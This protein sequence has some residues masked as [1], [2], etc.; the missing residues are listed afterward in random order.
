M[1]T[2]VAKKELFSESDVDAIYG[3]YDA[4]VLR[5]K[6]SLGLISHSYLHQLEPQ[7]LHTIVEAEF[8][9]LSFPILANSVGDRVFFEGIAFNAHAFMLI[10]YESHQS[11]DTVSAVR[12]HATKEELVPK[13]TT[14]KYV[15]VGA[16]PGNPYVALLNMTHEVQSD[17]GSRK[18]AVLHRPQRDKYYQILGDKALWWRA[19][20]MIDGLYMRQVDLETASLQKIWEARCRVTQL[21]GQINGKHMKD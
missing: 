13:T 6:T 20:R 18:S 1:D 16:E 5:S 7:P 14:C 19:E 12:L 10:L 2:S 11:K 17:G 8:N 3:S 15:L 21:M 9:V 4:V